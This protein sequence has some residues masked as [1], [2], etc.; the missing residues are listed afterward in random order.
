MIEPKEPGPIEPHPVLS[1]Y[2]ADRGEQARFIRNLFNET[3]SHYDRVDQLFSLG[4]GARY[5]RACLRQAGLRP[6]LRV[7]DVAVGTGLVAR[8]AVAIAGGAAEVVGLDLSEAMLAQARRN[9]AI[10]LI[11][12]RAEELPF[13]DECIDFLSMGYALR[14][15]SDLTLAFREFCRVLRPGGTVLLLEITKPSNPLY[16]VLASLYFKR[17]VPLVFRWTTGLADTRILMKYFWET[18][19]NC[20]PPSIIIQAMKSG[21]FIDTRCDTQ[22]DFLRNYVGRKP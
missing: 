21:G 20:V 8:E 9:L 22:W 6:G 15:V 14:H 10:P 12:G 5:R 3:A 2:Y 7:V 13:G 18:I 11:Q 4:S 1:A 16:R 17:V 19:D